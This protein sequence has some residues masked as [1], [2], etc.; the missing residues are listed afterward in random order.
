METESSNLY[1]D[2]FSAVPLYPHLSSGFRQALAALY[3]GLDLGHGLVVIVGVRGSG[4]TTLLRHFQDRLRTHN[5]TVFVSCSGIDAHNIWCALSAQLGIDSKG[6]DATSIRGRLEEELLRQG[7]RVLLLLD[8]SEDAD[9]GLVEVAEALTTFE[10]LKRG[11][12]YLVLGC[13]RGFAAKLEGARVATEQQCTVLAPLAAAE[14][15]SYIAHRL[16]VAGCGG[17]QLFA[18]D[19]YPLIAELSQGIPARVDEICSRAL[20]ASAANKQKPIDA[21]LLQSLNSPTSYTLSKFDAVDANLAGSEQKPAASKQKAAGYFSRRV[22]AISLGMLLCVL[23]AGLWYAA[24]RAWEM[25]DVAMIRGKLEREHLVGSTIK[26]AARQPS[27]KKPPQVAN[28]S[29]L[30]SSERRAMP[31][32]GPGS[33]TIALVPTPVPG[34]QKA[35]SPPKFSRAK[36]KPDSAPAIRTTPGIP[37]AAQNNARLSESSPTTQSN[38]RPPEPQSANAEALHREMLQKQSADDLSQGDIYMERGH[39]DQAL[40]SF[41]HALALSPGNPEITARIARVLRARA[42]EESTLR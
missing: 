20:A 4:K 15:E 1:V 36:T 40:Q 13:S 25:P 39:Y 19:A 32:V 28:P 14:V 24:P 21:S 8:S 17:E 27:A 34:T 11:L 37:A 22:K 33:A 7:G 16:R 26:I 5:R 29:D 38:N 3:Y 41:R 23:G 30:F 9:L 12:A 10:S 6:R 35:W 31:Q 18:T 2:A 42:A